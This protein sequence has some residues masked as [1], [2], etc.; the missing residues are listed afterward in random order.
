MI[1]ALEAENSLLGAILIEPRRFAEAAGLIGE[2]DFAG[3]QNRSVWRAIVALERA[4]RPI[5]AALLIDALAPILGAQR[6]GALIAD[7]AAATPTPSLAVEY[8]RSVADAATRRRL[9]EF[10]RKLAGDASDAPCSPDAT[11][12]LLAVAEY[13]L[14]RIASRRDTAAEKSVDELFMEDDW[15]IEHH[16][17]HGLPS[18]F[19]ALDKFFIGFRPGHLAILGGRTS[20]GKT[21]WA[22][23]VALHL[24]QQGNR[25]AF[26]SLEQPAAEIWLRLR[27]MEARVDRSEVRRRGLLPEERE[28]YARAAAALKELPLRV[29]YRPGIRPGALRAELKRVSGE[30]G[31]LDFAVVDYLGLMRPDQRGRERWIDA[32]EIVVALKHLAG[33]LE[34]PL[35]LLSQLNRD[36]KDSE[37][38]TLAQL[39]DTGAAEEHADVVFLLWSPPATAGIVATSSET[40]EILLAKQRNGVAFRKAALLFEKAWGRFQSA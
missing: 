19:D 34:I 37:P 30:L 13:D 38:P 12:E 40:V 21:S 36:A 32:R 5:D 22:L 7:L 35:L 26:V 6:A 15:R 23:N 20:R 25:V 4:R 16:A 17:D 33:E 2:D 39:R 24:A 29:L 10:G 18:G 1:A 27:D 14:A 28:R 8:A 3:E 9:A 31:G 11:A